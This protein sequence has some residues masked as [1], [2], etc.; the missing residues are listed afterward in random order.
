MAFSVAI[1]IAALFVGLSYE[2]YVL[3]LMM[4][5][6]EITFCICLVFENKKLKEQ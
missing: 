2:P 3:A 4:I 6:V 1:P 5:F